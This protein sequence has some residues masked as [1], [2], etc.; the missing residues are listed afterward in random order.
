MR[1]PTIYEDPDP[2]SGQ[3]VIIVS[4]RNPVSVTATDVDST[5]WDLDFIRFFFFHPSLSYVN[6]PRY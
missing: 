2:G 3:S 5:V 4:T 1:S 6:R